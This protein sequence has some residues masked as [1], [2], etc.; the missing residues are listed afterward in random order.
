MKDKKLR[1]LLKATRFVDC[2]EIK[3]LTAKLKL[4][5]VEDWERFIVW[6]LNTTEEELDSSP[7]SDYGCKA[8]KQWT[9]RLY[10]AFNQYFGHI[11]HFNKHGFFDAQMY[12]DWDF[13]RN[14]KDAAEQNINRYNTWGAYH[15]AGD[16]NKA[17]EF[18]S[19]PY[20]EE[21]RHHA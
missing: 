17:M 2:S 19:K 7:S 4:S 14:L 1:A 18:V 21:V 3:S 20:W 12:R 8:P 13:Y 6:R 9:N 16:L 11:A 5:I 10:H 15:D